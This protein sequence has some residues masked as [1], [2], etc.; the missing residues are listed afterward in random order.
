MKNLLLIVTLIGLFTCFACS[1]QETTI[2]I[3]NNPPIKGDYTFAEGLFAVSIG[4][5]REI[6]TG[7]AVITFSYEGDSYRIE[8]PTDDVV[9]Q[10]TLTKGMLSSGNNDVDYT[11]KDSGYT[12]RW[13]RI[14]KLDI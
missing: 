8:I 12:T 1:K 5:G 13:S 2:I 9:T 6:Q 4:S 3:D 14:K 10:I 11:T 7:A